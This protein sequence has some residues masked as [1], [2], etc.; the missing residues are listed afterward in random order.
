MS[1]WQGKQARWG[2]SPGRNQEHGEPLHEQP[3][4]P[5]RGRRWRRKPP[6]PEPPPAE[7]GARVVWLLG[8]RCV[9]LLLPS[10]EVRCSA[11][12]ADI[13]AGSRSVATSVPGRFYVL[14]N[15]SSRIWQVWFNDVTAY[16]CTRGTEA[17][18]FRASLGSRFV[19]CG[20]DGQ[21]LLVTGTP[22][23]GA[24]SPW[25]FDLE[26]QRWRALPAAPHAILSSAVAVQPD[27]LEVT[28][29]GG[30][31]KMSS[32]HG[33]VQRLT[34]RRP[35]GFWAVL[36][37]QLPWR[38]PGAGAFLE[39]GRLLVSLGWMECEG[40][41][42][43]QSFRLLPR[44]G[45]AQRARSSSSRL[46]ALSGGARPVVEELAVLPLADSFENLGQIF[47]LGGS[48]ACVGRDH[49]Q[50]FD[51]TAGTWQRW[52][53]PAELAVDGSSSWAKHCGSWAVALEAAATA[54][55]KSGDT[56]GP[57][58]GTDRPPPV[59]AVQAPRLT[60][61]EQKLVDELF[62]NWEGANF[63]VL[64]CRISQHAK[65]VKAASTAAL[66]M[67]REYTDLHEKVQVLK[68][69]REDLMQG[70][71][72]LAGINPQIRVQSD[73]DFF[74]RF[75]KKERPEV[76]GSQRRK[77]EGAQGSMQLI[78]EQQDL[79]AKLLEQ[80]ETQLDLGSPGDPGRKELMKTT[81]ANANHRIIAAR[82]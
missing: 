25:L 12:A 13:K 72:L 50:A 82:G 42:G 23:H 49:V 37:G 70:P 39:D 73:P 40:A 34:P 79:L 5:S 15:G 62:R 75:L 56:L 17:R 57:A 58:T 64:P 24:H 7:P 35:G 36:D 48:L 45:A 3:E 41:V 63:T 32:C 76:A 11:L 2:Q 20:P 60:D 1:D 38:R 67:E 28:I 6:S 8:N 71:W 29:L 78:R 10:G 26:T 66:E 19:S 4:G 61:E 16:I 22:H 77:Q 27:G 81:K 14:E 43:T 69:E 47:D 65:S 68:E 33:H 53:L 51:M 74:P 18:R 80:L 59:V 30:W 46:V 9:E 52:P 55:A 31:S 44:N 54:P 21:W